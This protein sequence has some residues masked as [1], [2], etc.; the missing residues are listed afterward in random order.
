M[1]RSRWRHSS[2]DVSFRWAVR[3]QGVGPLP[4]VA[5]PQAFLDVA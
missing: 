5:A 3:G 4:A 2:T 1:P